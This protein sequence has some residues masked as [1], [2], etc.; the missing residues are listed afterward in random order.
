MSITNIEVKLSREDGN[1]FFIMG[2]VMKAMRRVYNWQKKLADAAQESRFLLPL[3]IPNKNI[4]GERWN[5]E[6]REVS[7]WLWILSK[8]ATLMD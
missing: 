2:K 1:A 3:D 6:S 7:R 8:R 4:S 5:Q